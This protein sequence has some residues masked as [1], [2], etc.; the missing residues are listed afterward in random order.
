MAVLAPL[1]ETIG[2]TIIFGIF[3][4]PIAVAAIAVL[5]SDKGTIAKA[6][7]WIVLIPIVLLFAS[8]WLL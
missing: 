7:A 2:F 5:F 6:L 1:G 8:F 4:F 3:L